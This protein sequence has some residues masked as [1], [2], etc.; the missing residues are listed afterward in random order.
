MCAIILNKITVPFE[1]KS[2][3]RWKC[4]K[5]KYHNFI[6][7][8]IVCNW[9]RFS[10]LGAIHTS[11]ETEY[12]TYKILGASETEA[13]SSISKKIVCKLFYAVKNSKFRRKSRQIVLS[14][15]SFRW[16]V[17]CSFQ[18]RQIERSSTQTHLLLHFYPRRGV[19]CTLC[20]DRSVYRKTIP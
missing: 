7:N 4:W 16:S 14:K 20:K 15:I 18:M 17:N 5:R 12:N 11:I 2:I 10:I 3:H 9:M 19:H 13:K 1:N 6:L 8:L